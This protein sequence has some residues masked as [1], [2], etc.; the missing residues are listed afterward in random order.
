MSTTNDP[1][2]ADAATADK[3]PNLQASMQQMQQT[4]K[5]LF[6][7]SRYYAELHWDQLKLSIVKYALLAFLAVFIAALMA[8]L[9]IA[10]GI[11]LVIGFSYSLA[12]W[13]FDGNGA[14]GL[15]LGGA[16]IV[17]PVITAMAVGVA[18]VQ[19]RLRVQLGQKYETKKREQRARYGHDVE[20]RAAAA[21]A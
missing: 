21:A 13:L 17:M 5:E 4:F 7:Y 8:T 19:S 2:D 12:E 10:G 11:V 18:V 6:E 3:T 15:L 9:L 1:A 14:Y 20:Q 16:L